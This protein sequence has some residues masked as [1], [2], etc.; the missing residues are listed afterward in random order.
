MK[1][2]KVFLIGAGIIFFFLVLAFF[3]E[4]DSDFKDEANRAYYEEQY[5]NGS[6]AYNN[7][8]TGNSS[9]EG[10]SFSIEQSDDSS[11]ER[12]NNSSQSRGEVIYLSS[13]EFKQLVANY[14]QNKDLYV[15]NQPCVVDFYAGWCDQCKAIAPLLVKMAHNYAGRVLVYK[16]N[17]DEANDVSDAYNFQSIPTLFFC[18]GR[19]IQKIV[20]GFDV[21]VLDE[22]MCFNLLHATHFSP[23]Y[24]IPIHNSAQTLIH[25][26]VLRC[27]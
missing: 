16:V 5:T 25:I 14:S 18:S 7:N 2:F 1:V 27:K 21:S 15:G 8:N 19:D 17:I 23:A 26:Y 4:D 11:S 13:Q 12:T 20:G 24:T 6:Y 9:D 22:M 3:L 10:N